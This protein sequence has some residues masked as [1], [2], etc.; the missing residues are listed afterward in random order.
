MK[1]ATPNA[2]LRVLVVD[3]CQ[4]AADTLGTLVSFWGHEARVV[5]DGPE[6]LEAAEGF[7]PHII[8]LDISLPAMSGWEL[9]S[10]FQEMAATKSSMLVAVSALGA[11]EDVE[12][13]LRVGIHGHLVKPIDMQTLQ[14]VLDRV[15]GSVPVAD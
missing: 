11:E 12:H 15:A 8:L 4:E 10:R 7:Q 13:S 5:Y 9:A 1:K 3:D 6:A 14:Q 2:P